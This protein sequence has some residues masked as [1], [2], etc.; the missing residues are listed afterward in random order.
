LPSTAS[1]RDRLSASLSPKEMETEDETASKLDG[2][3][4][5]FLALLQELLLNKRRQSSIFV[6]EFFILVI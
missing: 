3:F 5:V 4:F 1:Q 2:A 6:T